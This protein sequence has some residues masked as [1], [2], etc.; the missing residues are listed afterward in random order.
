VETGSISVKPGRSIFP[1]AFNRTPDLMSSRMALCSFATLLLGTLAACSTVRES[2]TSSLGG[3]GE[4]LARTICSGSPAKVES[5]R[6]WHIPGQTDRLETRQCAAGTSTLY[7]GQT[8]SNPDGLAIAVE[9][10]TSGAGLP[11]YLEIGQPIQRALQR[12]G[13]PQEQTPGSAT[14]GLSLESADT[15][16]LHQSAGRITSVQWAWMVD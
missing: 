12:L 11:P 14:Y 13:V 16:T 10:V 2:P 5:V 4:R 8:T 9:I 15:I 3:L 7:R 6:N 1:S